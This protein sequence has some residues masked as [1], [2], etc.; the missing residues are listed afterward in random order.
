MSCTV[1]QCLVD[2]KLA[3][4]VLV[5]MSL[6]LRQD[7]GEHFKLSNIH[8]NI[9]GI[10]LL[11]VEIPNTTTITITYMYKCRDIQILKESPA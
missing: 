6:Q 5:Q 7:V 3:F 1:V 2:L 4:T 10:Y 11:F 9:C 8:L